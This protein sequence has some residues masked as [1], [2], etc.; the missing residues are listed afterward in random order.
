MLMKQTF[1]A[2]KH[3][4]K[5]WKNTQTAKYLR[6]N[7]VKLAHFAQKHIFFYY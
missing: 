1:C 4:A 2:K 5:I 3:G 6:K 7:L